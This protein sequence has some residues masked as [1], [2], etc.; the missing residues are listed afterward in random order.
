MLILLLLLVLVPLVLALAL[1]FHQAILPKETVAHLRLSVTREQKEG[2]GTPSLTHE[3][4]AKGKERG[5]EER[6]E[7]RCDPS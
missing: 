5:S 1:S 4:R 3:D 7:E 2:D 6:R